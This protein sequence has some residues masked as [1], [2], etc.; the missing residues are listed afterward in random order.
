M[1]FVTEI[2]LG[3][4]ALLVV[5]GLTISLVK[6]HRRALK[7]EEHAEHAESQMQLMMKFRG[8][9]SEQLKALDCKMGLKP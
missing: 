7:A 5:I 2:L 8:V 3:V 1:R 4:V 6:A 9:T